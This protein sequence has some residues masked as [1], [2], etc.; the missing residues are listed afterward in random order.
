MFEWLMKKNND[1]VG[2]TKEEVAELLKIDKTALEEFEK[3]YEVH[4]LTDSMPENFFEI[5]RAHV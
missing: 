4:A 1:H 5:G 2:L 3:S